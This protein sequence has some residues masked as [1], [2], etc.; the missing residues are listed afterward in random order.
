VR[1]GEYV[2]RLIEDPERLEHVELAAVPLHPLLDRV[3][4]EEL[5]HEERSPLVGHV[6]VEDRHGAR[7]IDL[8]GD[9]PLARK[10]GPRVVV[11]GVKPSAGGE[12]RDS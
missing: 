4:R 10:P 3:A 2:E 7:V 1:G 5:H 8:V 6:V 12:R 9:V 11:R